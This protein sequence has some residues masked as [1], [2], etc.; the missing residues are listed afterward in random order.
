VVSFLHAEVASETAAAAEL[1]DVGAEALQQRGV[2]AEPHDR[3]LMAVWLHDDLEALQA[4]QL[5]CVFRDARRREQFR[6]GEVVRSD[7]RGPGIAGEQLRLSAPAGGHVS[8][9]HADRHAGWADDDLDAI[10]RTGEVVLSSRRS[11]GTLTRGMT[12]WAV[13]V[14]GSV[15]IRSTDGPDKPWFRAALMR[16]RGRIEA[17]GRGV[18]IVFTDAADVDRAPIDEVYRRKYR[19]SPQYNVNRAASS[20]ATLK[21]E[22]DPNGSER[23]ARIASSPI[24]GEGPHA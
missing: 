8:M 7:V 16:G 24:S 15:F 3:M 11:D 18:D 9:T 22:P 10:N 6:E 4:R 20:M 17:G 23:P 21:L 14:D 19:P 1:H 5:K 2:G 12:I 13:V